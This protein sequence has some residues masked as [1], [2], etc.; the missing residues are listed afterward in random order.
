MRVRWT[1]RRS[2]Q[3]ELEHA[4]V[5]EAIKAQ[6]PR[7]ASAE[8]AEELR[9]KVSKKIGEE[10]EKFRKLKEIPVE[11]LEKV[12]ADYAA[13]LVKSFKE[14]TLT[15]ETKYTTGSAEDDRIFALLAATGIMNYVWRWSEKVDRL[16]KDL[17][18]KK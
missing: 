11:K 16:E 5:E 4:A 8:A 14:N 7:N 3:P 2:N 17:G 9:K 15:K 6:R 13:F 10:Y 1:A 12:C 18:L